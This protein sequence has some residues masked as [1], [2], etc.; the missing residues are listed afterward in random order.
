MQP[1]YKNKYGRYYIR[2][3]FRFGYPHLILKNYDIGVILYKG[4]ISNYVYNAPNKLFEYLA[5]GLDV[6]LPKKMTG[7]L[8][9]VTVATFPKI[10]ALDFLNL[11]LFNLHK[12]INRD[13]CF[14]QKNSFFCESVLKEIADKFFEKQAS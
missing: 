13:G 4:H 6:W 14:Y 3:I 2:K 10:L 5:C 8:E 11:Q 9:Y 1:D 7:S 12:A